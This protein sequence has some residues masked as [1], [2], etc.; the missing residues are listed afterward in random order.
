MKIKILLIYS[1][2]ILTLSACENLEKGLG[3]KKDKPNEFL[4]EKRDP[5]VMPPNYKIL[6]PQDKS[7]KKKLNENSIKK[8]L[9]ESL[10][11]IKEL[12][13]SSTSADSNLE[14]E[15]LKKIK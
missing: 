2:I 10:F 9:D 13:S 15:I 11:E 1:V 8:T 7:V 4:I 12:P 5:L 3:L 14:K 6:P